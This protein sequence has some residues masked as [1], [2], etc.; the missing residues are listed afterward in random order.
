M[1]N[2]ILEFVCNEFISNAT[3]NNSDETEITPIEAYNLYK[4]EPN[5][6]IIFWKDK[7]N[8][9]EKYGISVI[10]LV[11][12]IISKYLEGGKTKEQIIEWVMGEFASYATIDDKD[13]ITLL[14]AYN[15]YKKGETDLLNIMW[16]FDYEDYDD[17]YMIAM[18]DSQINSLTTFLE[19]VK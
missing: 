5:K 10:N 11:A 4:T 9:S 17:Q 13:D 12:D 3:L 2:K 8:F 19:G 14:E 1:K 18:V 6:V 7:F 15:L 16:Q